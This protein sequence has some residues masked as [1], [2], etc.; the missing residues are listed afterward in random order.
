MCADEENV[1]QKLDQFLKER[2]FEVI[3]YE[4]GFTSCYEPSFCPEVHFNGIKAFLVGDAGFQVKMT[5]VGGTFTG[6]WGAFVTSRAISENRSL[7]ELY[8]NLK[9]EMDIHFYI[10]KVLS[11]MNNDEY[12]RLL[13]K[14]SKKLKSIFYHLSRDRARKFFFQ[15]LLKEPYLLYLGMRKLLSREENGE[16]INE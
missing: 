1:R 13:L 2:N 10:R 4:E 12:D 7:K 3:E 15:M 8:K 5:T 11:K 6:F 16:W 9:R 14:V